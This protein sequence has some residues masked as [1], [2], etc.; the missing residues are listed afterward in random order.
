[1]GDS[2]IVNIELLYSTYSLRPVNLSCA[3]TVD[4]LHISCS[5]LSLGTTF[6]FALMKH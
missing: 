3:A 4:F 2:K 1:M 6:L 5:G